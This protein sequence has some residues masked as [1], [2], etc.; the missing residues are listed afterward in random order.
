MNGFS[1]PHKPYH[2]LKEE[3]EEENM[4]TRQMTPFFSSFRSNC[5]ILYLKIVKIHFYVVSL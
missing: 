3:T 2:F 1:D 4:R 5:F